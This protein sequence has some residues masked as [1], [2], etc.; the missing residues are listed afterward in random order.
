MFSQSTAI[1]KYNTY[2][3]LTKKYKRIQLV[4]LISYLDTTLDL[5]KFFHDWINSLKYNNTGKLIQV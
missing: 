1:N 2:N 3:M 4:Q 5:R